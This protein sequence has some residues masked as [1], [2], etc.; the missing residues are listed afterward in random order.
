MDK[1][2]KL[3][4]SHKIINPL[5][6]RCVLKTGA[7]GKKLIL[8]LSLN[9]NKNKN[10][11]KKEPRM[12]VKKSQSP[13]KDPQSPVK[14]H[15]SPVKNPQS[16]VKNPQSPLKDPIDKSHNKNK[17]FL[18]RK[19][20]NDAFRKLIHPSIP[21]LDFS[22]KEIDYISNP[23]DSKWRNQWLYKNKSIRHICD[24]YACIGGDTIQFMAIK[25]NAHIDATQIT[26]NNPLLIQRFKRLNNN[27]R[28]CS[29][30]NPFVH[31]HPL[32]ITDFI[33]TSP[34]FQSVDF[35][36]CDPPW[37][38]IQNNWFDS[39]T[40]ISNLNRDIFLP[41]ISKNYKPKFICFK[42]PF[43]WNDFNYVLSL[44]PSYKYNSSGKFHFN[45]Y[46][47]HIIQRK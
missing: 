28:L 39:S 16:P 6:N 25:P 17:Y 10:K 12:P 15:Q 38:D 13:V 30:L 41:L 35:L 44:L 29:F 1:P 31:I 19:K 5:T 8:D 46:W 20:L 42:V 37:T 24:A 40:L 4:P 14:D 18:K 45:G 3:C 21:D 2:I 22:D 11:N 33:L 23:F 26:D 47:I 7:I 43:H 36:Y 9:K 34:S 27:I 32:S